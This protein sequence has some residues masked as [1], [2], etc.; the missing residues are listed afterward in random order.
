MI[1]A[2]PTAAAETEHHRGFQNFAAVCGIVLMA[3]VRAERARRGDA[4]LRPLKRALRARAT[5]C[6]RPRRAEV[7]TEVDEAT[8]HV[9]NAQAA[10]FTRTPRVTGAPT[11]PMRCVMMAYANATVGSGRGT[12]AK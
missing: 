11:V 10:A 12:A 8:H 2:L 9:R 5:P 3:G 1:R 6:R 4:W 7:A